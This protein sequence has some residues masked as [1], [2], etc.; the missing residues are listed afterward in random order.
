ML[1]GA[2]GVEMERVGDGGGDH[3]VVVML[4]VVAE[5][6]MEEAMA[7]VTEEDRLRG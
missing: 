4:L 1:V 7:G 5:V 6:V 2:G 3:G